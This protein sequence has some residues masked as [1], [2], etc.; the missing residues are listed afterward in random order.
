MREAWW[1]SQPGDDVQYVA[2]L[3]D[4]TYK[5]WTQEG[6]DEQGRPVNRHQRVEHYADGYHSRDWY[7][8][9]PTTDTFGACDPVADLPPRALVK[10]GKLME[11]LA[12]HA[13][14]ARAYQ[15]RSD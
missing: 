3:F 12:W 1:S 2:V 5:I 14:Y 15:D 11:P 9:D 10:R 4:Q 13:L 8:Y 6:W 7:W